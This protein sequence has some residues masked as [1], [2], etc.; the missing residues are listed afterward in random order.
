MA[1]NHMMVEGAFGG[2]L[3]CVDAI[4]HGA[5]RHED[6]RLTAILACHRG[7]EAENIAG[8]GLACDLFEGDGREMVTTAAGRG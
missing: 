7:G 3:A 5:A 1:A 8:L 2:L 4:A 6:D